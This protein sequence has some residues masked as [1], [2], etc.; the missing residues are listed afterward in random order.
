VNEI[1]DTM[2]FKSC[3]AATGVDIPGRIVDFVVQ[4]A[5]RANVLTY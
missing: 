5:Q 2:E 1:N 3:F 4:A